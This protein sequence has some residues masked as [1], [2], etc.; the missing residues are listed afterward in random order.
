MSIYGRLGLAHKRNNM[1][2]GRNI[3]MAHCSKNARKTLQKNLDILQELTKGKVLYP[4]ETRT[5]ASN[6]IL[7]VKNICNYHKVF[8]LSKL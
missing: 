7:K 3:N 8:L 4:S 1:F 2:L 6:F 5:F